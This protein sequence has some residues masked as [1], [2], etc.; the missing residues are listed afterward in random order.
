MLR[1]PDSWVWDTWYAH[2]GD[3]YHAFFLY[4]SR[5]LH[6]PQRRHRRASVGHAVSSDLVTWHRVADA[7][8]RGDAPDFD[9]TATWTGCVVQ[10][11]DRRWYMFYTGVT[12]TPD[13]HLIQQ[14]GLAVSADLHTWHKHEG[15]PLLSADGRWYEK[16][17]GPTGWQDEH[18]RDPWV[19]RDPAGDGWHMLVTAR[20]C[21]G[22]PDQRGVI[23]HATSPDLISWTAQPPM[24]QP[25]TGFG[26][27]EV[28]QVAR[29]DGRWVLVFNC[30][31]AELGGRR[32]GGTG[33]VWVA[34]AQSPLGPYDVVNAT[35]LTDERHYVG[36]LLQDP[37]GAWV[38]IA[39]ANQLDGGAFVGELTDPI[40]VRWSD[41]R[42]VLGDTSRLQQTLPTAM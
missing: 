28:F 34:D 26:Q 15:N 29:V 4:A 9:Q 24:S 38:L 32:A 5:A 42:L 31:S 27:M 17:G 30:M 35:L 8:V 16:R 19:L 40:P 22:A 21:S 13:E 37:T 25:D 33:G 36:K 20:A 11:D 6:D 3:T 2:D 1:L 7:L 39:F 23:G 41:D 14:I 18:W 12:E 10:G